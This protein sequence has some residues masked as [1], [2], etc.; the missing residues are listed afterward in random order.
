MSGQH[1]IDGVVLPDPVRAEQVAL[2]PN[3]CSQVSAGSAG[4]T[5][6]GDGSL[7]QWRVLRRRRRFAPTLQCLHR[8][9]DADYE[10]GA[11]QDRDHTRKCPTHS[12]VQ[13]A[14]SSRRHEQGRSRLKPSRFDSAGARRCN[15]AVIAKLPGGRVGCD[16]CGLL[17]DAAKASTHEAWHRTEEERLDRLIRA[18]GELVDLARGR[19]T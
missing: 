4:E 11:Q 19:R 14:S 1:E 2:A 10:A 7:A 9:D 15:D 16:V 17:L 8:H 5:G 3:D 13:E 12:R 18:V 6:V